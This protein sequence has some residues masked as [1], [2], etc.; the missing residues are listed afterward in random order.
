VLRHRGG[1]LFELHDLRDE[2]LVKQLSPARQES[3]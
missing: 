2:L 1:D 3:F